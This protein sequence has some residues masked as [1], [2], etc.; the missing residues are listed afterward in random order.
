LTVLVGDANVPHPLDV[1]AASPPGPPQWP[2]ALGRVQPWLV[3]YLGWD[4]STARQAVIVLPSGWGPDS[5]PP[6]VPLVIS[7][8]GRNNFGWNNAVSYWQDLPAD[9]PFALVCPDGLGRAHD[10]AS[11]PFDQPPTNP[12]LFTY[13]Y[14]PQIADLARMPS[15]VQETL[16]WLTID[17]DRV[18]VLG[19][20]MG[21]Q[22]TLLLTALY[23]DALE[24]G[25]GRLVGAAAFDSPCDLATQCGYLTNLSPTADSNPPGTAALM[26]EEVGSKP[27]D[28]SGFNQAGLFYNEKTTTHMTIGQL[29]NE[30]PEDQSL[31]DERSPIRYAEQLAALSFPLRLYW[32][33]NDAVVGNQGTEQTGKLYNLI[34]AANPGAGVVQVEGNWAHS[35][36]FVPG[37]CLSDALRT[38]GLIT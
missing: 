2:P 3:Q 5:P 19:S 36:E 7:P 23:P 18:Y 28:L 38:Y 22:E 17:L 8:H 30:L 16:T 29:L 32:S 14:P 26:L 35:V 4:G 34:Q 9:G 11:D 27:A 31:W 24:G 15:I 21:G 12:G 20:S 33:S 13:G 37:D 1:L 25:T 10:K 6:A